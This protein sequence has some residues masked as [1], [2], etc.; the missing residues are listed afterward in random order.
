MGPGLGPARARA[1]VWYV[2]FVIIVL[3]VVIVFYYI[4]S[5]D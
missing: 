1:H 4:V 2:F 3:F 5:E